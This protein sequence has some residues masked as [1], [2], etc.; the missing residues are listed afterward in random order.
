MTTTQR[1]PHWDF[2]RLGPHGRLVVIPGDY[3]EGR[4]FV[5]NIAMTAGIPPRRMVIA[6]T[7]NHIRGIGGTDWF[8][9]LYGG[10]DHRPYREVAPLLHRMREI[11][12]TQ[13]TCTNR[14]I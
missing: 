2:T 9:V 6:T 8:Y 1:P 5:V 7:E 3:T 11:G 10:W 13:L 12:A 14:D 4:F